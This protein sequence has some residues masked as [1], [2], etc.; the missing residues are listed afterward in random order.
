[1]RILTKDFGLEYSKINLFIKETLGFK[2]RRRKPILRLGSYKPTTFRWWVVDYYIL[3]A[4]EIG[5]N[6]KYDLR[7]FEDHINADK[8]LRSISEDYRKG[9][10]VHRIY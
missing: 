10:K 9:F 5:C 3:Q 1:M 4:K 8:C 7:I 6:K 2:G